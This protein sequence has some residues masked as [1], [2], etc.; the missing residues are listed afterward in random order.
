MP[1]A[2]LVLLRDMLLEDTTVITRTKQSLLRLLP[3]QLEAAD[4]GSGMGHDADRKRGSLKSK[5]G[6]S[7]SSSHPAGDGA[8]SSAEGTNSTRSSAR[9]ALSLLV[10]LYCCVDSAEQVRCKHARLCN[11]NILG[12]IQLSYRPD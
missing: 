3:I 7:T 1:T 9:I 12:S 5:L 8:G 11:A 10:H 6:L 4:S 2:C